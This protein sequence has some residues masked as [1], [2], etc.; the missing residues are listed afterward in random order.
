[1]RYRCKCLC[2]HINENGP[3]AAAAA[4]TSDPVAAGINNYAYAINIYISTV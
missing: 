1:M 3:A 2:L 4:I